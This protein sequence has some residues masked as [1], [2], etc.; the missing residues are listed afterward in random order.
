MTRLRT[1]SSPAAGIS[2]GSCAVSAAVARGEEALERARLHARAAGDRRQEDEIVG[3]L[4]CAA[5]SGPQ[6]VPDAGETLC[7]SARRGS[8]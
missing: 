7:G 1:V 6:P 4:G 8:G 3:R 5:W 2:S